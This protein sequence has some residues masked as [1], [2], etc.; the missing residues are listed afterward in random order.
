MTKQIKCYGASLS[1]MLVLGGTL[2]MEMIWLLPMGLAGVAVFAVLEYSKI[3]ALRSVIA[4]RLHKQPP[5]LGMFAG[6]IAGL[7]IMLW[8]ASGLWMAGLL[9]ERMVLSI[10]MLLLVEM[11]CL[12]IPGKAQKREQIPFQLLYASV[13]KHL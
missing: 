5:G 13:G 7:L 1:L 6:M 4:N 8:L 12:A 3:W 10:V 9:T 2:A 11:A